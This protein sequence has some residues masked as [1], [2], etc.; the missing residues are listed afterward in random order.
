[1]II[2]VG[3]IMTWTV[4]VDNIWLFKLL[5]ITYEHVLTLIEIFLQALL[6]KNTYSDF[7][8]AEHFAETACF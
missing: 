5:Q 7:D 8:N 4:I 3:A 2:I 6:R 1:M